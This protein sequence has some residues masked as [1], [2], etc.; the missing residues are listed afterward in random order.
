MEYLGSNLE[1]IYHQEGRAVPAGSSYEYQYTIKD[2]LGNSRLMFK[3][4]GSTA[5]IIQENHYYPFGMDMQG[6][7]VNGSNDYKYNGKVVAQ[8]KSRAT[9]AGS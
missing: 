4:V 7:F 2:H 3:V 9:S 6:G 1:A 8:R 5:T